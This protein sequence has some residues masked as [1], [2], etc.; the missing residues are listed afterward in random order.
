ME[1]QF[2]SSFKQVVLDLAKS[3][4]R[5]FSVGSYQSLHLQVPSDITESKRRNVECLMTGSP[6]QLRSYKP[7]IMWGHPELSE[8][9]LAQKQ[10]DNSGLKGMVPP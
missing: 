9:W 5:V 2:L 1:V 6:V 10:V 3:L 7:Q 8:V 4:G